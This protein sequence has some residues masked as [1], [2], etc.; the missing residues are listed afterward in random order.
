MEDFDLDRLASHPHDAFIKDVLSNPVLAAALFK[1]HFPPA[2][3]SL[4][5][6]SSLRLEPGS[7]VKQSLHQAH[8]D[9]LFSI[10]MEGSPCFLYML[11]EH[12]TTV[13]EMMP[14]RLLNYIIE[15]MRS[16]VEIHGLPLP[17]VL[18]M[19][20]H[21]GPER[22]TPS[23]CFEDMFDLSPAHAEALLP[24]LPKFRHALLDLSQFDPQK[25]GDDRNLKAILWLAKCA[26]EN[27][28]TEHLLGLIIQALED[29]K[30]RRK[31]LLYGLHAKTTLDVEAIARTV[32]N[33]DPLK[34]EIMSTAAALIA[35][36]NAEGEARGIAK[37]KAEGEAR[38]KAEGKLTVLQEIMGLPVSSKEDLAGL[39]LADLE[40]RYQEMQHRYDSQF[41]R[42]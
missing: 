38:G 26:R 17:P 28:L 4:M 36:G 2:V 7:F 42:A 25:Q 5:D 40:S 15:I 27:L 1:E 13:D 39:D 14:F 6:W 29:R 11:F 37:G 18:P 16:H 30:L 33:N 12:Q 41:K 24:F 22:W 21:Q 31:G 8:S 3:T 19:V 32:E 20:F 35:K 23:P 9:L 10:Q 34:E